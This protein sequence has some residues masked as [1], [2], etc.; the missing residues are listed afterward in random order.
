[1]NKNILAILAC[2]LGLQS[3][4]QAFFLSDLG[5][6]KQKADTKKETASEAS[7]PTTIMEA[8]SSNLKIGGD[9]TWVSF[10]PSG[11]STF[12]GNLGGMQASY[13]Y[14]VKDYF[15]AEASL[16]W[17]EGDMFGSNGK[18]SLTYVDAQ[19]RL[20]YT[21]G[22]ENPGSLLTLYTG[23]GYR[24]YGQ[25]FAPE[26]GNSTRYYYNHIYIP[27]GLLG[28]YDVTSYFNLGVDFTWMPQVY[29][30]VSI[31]PLD[32]ARWVLSKRLENF[33]VKL[34]LDFSLTRNKKFHLILTPFYERWQ[35]GH[36]TAETS[37]GTQLGLPS[38]TYNFYGVNL[39]FSYSF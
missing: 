37:T 29:P 8:F 2:A 1:M 35:D 20:G 5:H 25:K 17:K 10:K 31:D 7:Q 6:P 14:K 32:G 36:S 11:Y 33:Y 39:D 19:E 9:Y 30:T 23:V 15:Y 21:L 16:A 27:V 13:E 26:N 12:T 34:P 18:R 24:H 4:L 28:T 38:N 22:L 3:S